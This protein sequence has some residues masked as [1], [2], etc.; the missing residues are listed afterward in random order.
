MVKT[1]Y[2]LALPPVDLEALGKIE[3]LFLGTR[4]D[5][6]LLVARE[7]PREAPRPITMRPGDFRDSVWFVGVVKTF[8]FLALT[9]ADLAVLKKSVHLFLATR[10]E[11]TL[12]VARELPGV[13]QRPTAVRS[14]DR[15]GSVWFVG[16]SK[17][18]VS[19]P[20]LTAR[21]ARMERMKRPMTGLE[22]YE[23][24]RAWKSVVRRR[25]KFDSVA[26]EEREVS[27]RLVR[28]YGSAPVEA[29]GA[30]WVPYMRGGKVRYARFESHQ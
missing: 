10:G 12:M 15:R 17:R 4:A 28:A 14:G 29:F 5:R 23:A 1:F 25:L 9:P 13:L 18:S 19:P 3:H 26:A 20:K 21:Q 8:Y 7:L 2:F 24:L 16:K 11:K 6:T 27:R 22:R 30:K